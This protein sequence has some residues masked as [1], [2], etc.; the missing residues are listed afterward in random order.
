MIIEQLTLLTNQLEETRHFYTKVFP[1]ELVDQGDS[2]FTVKVGQT[3]LTFQY[4]QSETDPFYHFT[5]N[6]PENKFAEAVEWASTKVDFA[7]EVGEIVYDCV[8]W[9]SHSVY[10]YDPAGNIVEFIARHNLNN[11][12][13]HPF[14]PKDFLYVSE[15]GVVTSDIHAIV[16]QLNEL[17]IPSWNAEENFNPVGD[18]H[19]LFIIVKEGRRWLYSNKNAHFYDVKATVKGLGTLCFEQDGDQVVIRRSSSNVIYST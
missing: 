6:I 4:K 17:G 3:L 10:F 15:V 11:A 13:N 14:S 16:H 7:E 18:E 19:G 1:F 2:H 8:E 5:F 12:V 9:N